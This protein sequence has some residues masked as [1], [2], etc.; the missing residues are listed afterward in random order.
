M[1]YPSAKKRL[2]IPSCSWAE[3]SSMAQQNMAGL[4]QQLDFNQESIFTLTVSQKRTVSLTVFI[5]Y[6]KIM[7]RK[8]CTMQH[9]LCTS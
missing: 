5:F 2:V 9:F 1:F 8:Y 3:Q 4:E 7:V 6:C